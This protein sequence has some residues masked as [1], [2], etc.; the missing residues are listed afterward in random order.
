MDFELS[1]DQD[2]LRK[3][4]REFLSKECPKDRTR[5]LMADKK[6]YDT[7]M[8]K[9]MAQLGFIGLAIEEEYGGAGGNFLELALFM[10]EVGRNIVPSPYFTTVG[11]C[12]SAI[13]EFGTEDQKQV[14]LTKIAT[15]GEIWTLALNEKKGD[16]DSNE[17]RLSAQADGDGYRINGT[18]LFVPYANVAKKF[19]VAARTSQSD[20]PE[21]GITLFIVDAKSDGIEIEVIPTAARDMK[22]EVRFNNVKAG[23]D[24][25]LGEVNGGVHILDYVLQF[26]A[27]LKSAEMSGG[28][29]EAL[30]IATNYAK[31]R[32][33]FDKPI[34][35][36]QSLQHRLVR[37]LT[38]VDGLKNLVYEAAWNMSE[39]RPDRMLNSLVK[40]KANK[41]YH[42]V[43]YDAVY[44]HGAIG[45]TAEMDI[46]LY[47]LRAKANEN[48]CGGTDFHNERVA[49]ELE[50]YKP[51]F[52]SLMQ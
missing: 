8:W 2:L 9:K 51:D 37:M 35:S 38:E 7:K 21:D 24:D 41:T 6:G 20:N 25:V 47:L 30:K 11:L 28:V 3:S 31:Q 48:D 13:A 23:R 33:Q 16:W 40:V 26:G 17:I 5:E 12:A 44:L 32:Y 49:M 15:K 42:R 14:A 45:W 52:L 22:C 1:K 27:V 18:K 50:Q 39:G 4:A 34:G 43:C 29:Q 19:L 10:E 36:F 46:S